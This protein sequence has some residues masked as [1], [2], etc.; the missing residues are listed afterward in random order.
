MGVVQEPGRFLDL[1][2]FFM[3][4]FIVAV[5]G[6]LAFSGFKGLQVGPHQEMP[7]RVCA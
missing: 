4:V 5:V 2:T 6:G 7:C 3:Y 1:Q